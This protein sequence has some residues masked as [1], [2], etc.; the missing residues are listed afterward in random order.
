MLLSTRWRAAEPE[1]V[2]RRGCGALCLAAARLACLPPLPPLAEQARGLQPG[3][4]SR[5]RHGGDAREEAHALQALPRPV[6]LGGQLRLARAVDHGGHVVGVPTCMEAQGF[7]G[8]A[9]S[10]SPAHAP[11][12]HPRFP[13]SRCDAAS[14]HSARELAFARGV[15]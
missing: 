7:D 4:D 11:P 12:D 10:P 3:R 13:S 5:A 9:G 2:P 14:Q 8:R 6:L 15:H 1:P